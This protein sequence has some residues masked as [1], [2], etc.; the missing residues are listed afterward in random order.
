MTVPTISVVIP[1]YNA[2]TTIRRAIDSVLAQTTPPTEILVVDDGSPDGLARVV[3]AYGPAVT[4]IQQ[5]NSRSAAARNRGIDAATGDFVAFLD[6]DDYWEPEKLHHQLSVLD[7]HPQVDVV[8]GRYFCQT[9][10]EDR[11]RNET[12]LGYLY[13]RPLRLAGSKAFLL[14][15]LFWTGTVIVRRSVFENNRFVSGLEPAEDR[16]LWVRLAAAHTV[17]MDSRPLSTAVLEPGSISRASISV[18]CTKMLEVIDR[19]ASLLGGPARQFWKSY[20]RYRWAAIDPSP[21]RSLPLLMRSI[22]GWPFP[23]TGMPTMKRLGRLKRL[24]VLLKHSVT[25]SAQPEGSS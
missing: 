9:P 7:K 2:E 17:W 10:G 19:N 1:A 16:D 11:C 13:D 21:A 4:L 22:I 25:D 23:L 3:A 24:L 18:D 8:A 5:T 15:T 12:R 6:A 14:G 20:V